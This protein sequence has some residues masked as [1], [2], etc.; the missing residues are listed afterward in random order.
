MSSFAQRKALEYSSM[1]KQKSIEEITGMRN[2]LLAQ[3]KGERSKQSP[4]DSAIQNLN[5]QLSF[6]GRELSDRK[7]VEKKE[8]MQT[9]SDEQELEM[10]GTTESPLKN[11]TLDDLNKML[12]A[13][14][15]EL[16]DLKEFLKVARLTK[17]GVE[18]RE[19]KAK[20]LTAQIYDIKSEVATRS[21]EAHEEAKQDIKS[22][23]KTTAGKFMGIDTDILMIGSA[24]GVIGASIGWGMGKNV[25]VIAGFA[26]IGAGVGSGI[27]YLAKREKT[28]K[29]LPNE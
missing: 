19:D 23:E 17:E 20:I 27:V 2:N 26:L 16:S 29:P 18:Q 10:G 21:T 28:V 8:P 11:R 13:T 12:E 4:D 9:I 1:L 3:L 22:A 7:P 25:W 14:E 6:L 24:S 5:W 15:K